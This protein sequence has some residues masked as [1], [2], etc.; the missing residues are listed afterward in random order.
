VITKKKPIHEL[1][2]ETNW[3][4]EI[5]DMMNELEMGLSTDSGYSTKM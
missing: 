3:A 5:I 4:C 1:V 2:F